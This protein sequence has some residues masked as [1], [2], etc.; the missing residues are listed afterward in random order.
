MTDQKKFVRCKDRLVNI[1]EL[2]KEGTIPSQVSVFFG[3]NGP[4]VIEVKTEK[5]KGRILPAFS[6]KK[7][8]ET[9]KEQNAEF[10]SS[11][12]EEKDTEAVIV[13]IFQEALFLLNP[14]PD[15]WLEYETC[16]FILANN[17][18]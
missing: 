13:N 9:F 1:N 8:A 10:G 7:K 4:H 5:V 18:Q 6:D 14:K 15:N 16:F 12:I 17:N 11:A 3:V 2:I